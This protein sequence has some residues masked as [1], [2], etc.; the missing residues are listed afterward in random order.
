[1]PRGQYV[2]KLKTEAIT[3]GQKLAQALL[4]YGQARLQVGE[5]LAML[6]TILEP[7]NL[8][9]RFLRAF[10]FSQRTAYRYIAGYKNASGRLPE[11][12]LK[13][14]MARG[15]NIVGDTEAK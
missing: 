5:H 6:Q 8:F 3:E 13:A 4:H 12:V 1:M 14:A 11:N 7:H 9:V 2:R 10:R 15:I